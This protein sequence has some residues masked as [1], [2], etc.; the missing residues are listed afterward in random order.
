MAALIPVEIPGGFVNMANENSIRK[1]R[2]T[3]SS[4]KGC[5][6]QTPSRR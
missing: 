6:L 1:T 5:I 2:S 4:T 3:S